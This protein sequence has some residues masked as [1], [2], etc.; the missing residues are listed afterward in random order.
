[1]T[2]VVAT[3]LAGW[4]TSVAHHRIDQLVKAW[5]SS[6]SQA[7]APVAMCGCSDWLQFSSAGP[8][9]AGVQPPVRT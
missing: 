6:V 1:M 8:P 4:L 3:V 7:D 9:N 2:H 5:Q